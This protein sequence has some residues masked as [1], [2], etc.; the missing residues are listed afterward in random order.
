VIVAVSVL[1]VVSTGAEKDVTAM[2][3]EATPPASGTTW[4]AAPAFRLLSVEV[5]VPVTGPTAAGSKLMESVQV[6]PAANGRGV[7]VAGVSCGQVPPPPRTNPADG[8][9]LVPVAGMA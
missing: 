5:R 4:V 6:V 2:V 1:L 8:L 3:G 7:A 9:G